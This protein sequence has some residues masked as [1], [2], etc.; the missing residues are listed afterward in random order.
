MEMIDLKKHR[1]YVRQYVDLR[2]AYRD[3]LL[4]S[5]VT[6]DETLIWLETMDVEIRC[7]VD[8]GKL[9]GAVMLYVHKNG[10]VAFFA[11]EPRKG[12]GSLLLQ[13]IESVARERDVKTVWAWVLMSNEA[14]QAA[15]RKNGY[16]VEQRET[17]K[18][19]ASEYQGILFT[20]NIR[21][22]SHKQ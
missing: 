3:V 18:Y 20:K 6:P 8:H 19:G 7:L 1:A 11:R 14:A 2:N 17:K 4:T 10:E 12:V 16:T 5:E 15:F 13:T 9:M 21:E 22:A